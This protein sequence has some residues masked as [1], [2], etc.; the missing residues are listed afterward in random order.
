MVVAMTTLNAPAHGRPWNLEST[1]R[2][3][4]VETVIQLTRRNVVSRYCLPGGVDAGR[5]R[6]SAPPQNRAEAVLALER[7]GGTDGRVDL[8]ATPTA[9]RRSWSSGRRLPDH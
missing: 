2:V 3:D 4:R 6:A 1:P 5:F 9:P 7:G 8:R